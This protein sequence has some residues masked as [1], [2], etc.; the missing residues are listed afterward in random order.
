[1]LNAKEIAVLLALGFGVTGLTACENE[2]PLERAAENTDDALDDAG[3][4]LEDAGD[5][6]KDKA[7]D[8]AD[9]I[10]DAVDD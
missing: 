3:D 4:N 6:I 1:M 10:E 8:V 2:G 7:E 9:D 5:D